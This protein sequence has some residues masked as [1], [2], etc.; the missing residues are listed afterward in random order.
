MEYWLEVGSESQD[1]QINVSMRYFSVLY[2]HI[3]YKIL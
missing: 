3:H 1:R 2:L